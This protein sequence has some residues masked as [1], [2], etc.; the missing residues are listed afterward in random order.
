MHVVPALAAGGDEPGRGDDRDRPGDDRDRPDLVRGVPSPSFTVDELA[1]AAGLP[2]RT[3]RHYQSEKV[4]PP[5]QRRGRIAVYG[6]EHLDRLLLIGRLQDRGLR[7]AAIR[8]VFKRVE[9]GEVWLDDWL[10]LGDELRAPWSEERPAVL[11][12]AELAERVGGRP[13]A[14]A[15]LV[16][17]GLARRQHGLTSTYLVPSLGLL[18]IT[19]QLDAAG[20]D[21]DT[22]ASAAGT[23]RKHL[24]RASSDLVDFF[25]ER[26]GAGFAR[27]GS[28]EDI[29]EALGALRPLGARAVQLVFIQEIERALRHAVEQGRATPAPPSS[30]SPDRTTSDADRQRTGTSS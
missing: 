25:L 29:T 28:I 10:G 20:V 14:V 26:A 3:V 19:L 23:I 21:I 15:A 27:R 6:Q 7:L 13:G 4:L 1:A 18:D 12:E 30:E 2:V 9:K 5:P 24:R 8:D 17:A 16:A 22:A 11:T